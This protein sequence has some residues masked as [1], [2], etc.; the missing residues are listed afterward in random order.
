MRLHR[1]GIGIGI[2]IG[3]GIGIVYRPFAI[4]PSFPFTGPERKN[5]FM[6][7]KATGTPAFFAPEMCVKGAYDG[8]LADLWAAG[9]TLC[10]I[11]GGAMPFDA[12]N[13]PEVFRRFHHVTITWPSRGHHVAITW[14]SR[15]HHVAITWPQAWDI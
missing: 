11:V 9:V 6:V 12:D 4:G 3:F 14:P 10:M 13:M 5:E 1:P 7:D 8:M 2:G 15:G